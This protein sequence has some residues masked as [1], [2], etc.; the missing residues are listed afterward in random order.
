LLA[1]NV[2]DTLKTQ[3]GR[4]LRE[5]RIGKQM[6]Q[7]QLAEAAHISVDF[8]SLIER[9]RNAL[10]FKVVEQLAIALH[11]PVKE[12]FNFDRTKKNSEDKDAKEEKYS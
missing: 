1:G 9:G 5:L 8:L 2:V 3:F 7:E 11:M 4:R 10:S 6:T 12:L